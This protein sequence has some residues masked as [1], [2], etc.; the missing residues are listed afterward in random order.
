VPFDGGP[1]DTVVPNITRP[2]SGIAV[3]TA[4]RTVFSTEGVIWQ[5][6]SGS[7]ARRITTPEKDEYSHV[8]PQLIRDDDVLLFTART[9]AWTWGNERVVAQVLATGERRVLVREGADARYVSTGH[10]L[11]VRRGLLMAV[12]FDLAR[13]QVTGEPVALLDGVAQALTSTNGFDITGAGHFRISSTGSLA[14]ISSPVIPFPEAA[15]VTVDRQG[16]ENRLP[17][18]TRSYGPPVRVS[19]DR[20]RLAVTVRTVRAQALWIVDVAR[21]SGAQVTAGEEIYGPR[22][23]PDGQRIA[24][25]WV[26]KGVSSLA[27]Q[28]ADG[29]APP[30][31]WVPGT[32]AYPSSWTPDGQ[33]LVTSD[34]GDLWVA[35]VGERHATLERITATSETEWHPELSP[36]GRWLAYAS[37]KTGR[38]EV[39][40]R[41]YPDPGPAI[42]VSVDGGQSPAWNSR[43]GELFF[44]SVRDPAGRYRLMA[45]NIQGSRVGTPRAL[46]D[47]PNDLVFS[48]FIVRCY[49]VS[50]DG[51]RFFVTKRLPTLPPPP[52]TEINLVLNWVEELKA[53]VPVK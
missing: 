6:S 13:L 52:V 39:Y 51:Q 30:D 23:T 35:S 44:H 43:G 4:G 25:R 28:R 40:I 38:F 1:A 34:E 12:P 7:E 33:H 32:K 3:G 19:P 22:W 53:K 46:F 21:G 47:I 10:L 36:D 20:H 50:A 49:D 15:L 31:V 24:F 8:L 5:V 37:D 45:V 42:P 14:Y 27:W 48:C 11:F 17:V 29:S 9:S 41:P 18:E 16:R 26:A 2:P